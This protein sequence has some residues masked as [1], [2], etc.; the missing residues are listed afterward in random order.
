MFHVKLEY[1]F[2]DV[3]LNPEWVLNAASGCQMAVKK[4]FIAWRAGT[5]LA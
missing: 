5:L 4:P 2:K 3:K 1:F